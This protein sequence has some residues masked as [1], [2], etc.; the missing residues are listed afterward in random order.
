MS[1]KRPCNLKNIIFDFG[2]VLLEWHPNRVYQDFFKNDALVQ[3]FYEETQIMVHNREMDRGQAFDKVL[4][5]L[6]LQHPHYR[7]AL[8]LWK[9][10]WHKMLGGPIQ[11]SVDILYDLAKAGYRLFGLTNWA[12]ETFPYVFYSYDFFQVFEDIV[13]S[14]REGFIKPER[15]IFDLCLSRNGI[16]PAESVFIDDNLDNIHAAENLGLCAIQ[17]QDAAQLRRVLK[18][19]GLAF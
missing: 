10:S 2:G 14:G 11:G 8:L 13:V 19:F 15:E 12:A 18:E 9:N 7:Q 6:I 16:N 17:F 3:E 5:Q 1:A 4:G